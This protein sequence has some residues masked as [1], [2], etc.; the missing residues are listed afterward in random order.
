MRFSPAGALS[1]LL[2]G[3]AVLAADRLHKFVQLDILDW[4][5]GEAVAVTSFFNYVLV[6]NTGVS[7]GL[8]SGVPPAAILAI[9]GVAMVFLA[10][11]WVA[12]GAPRVRLGLALCLGGALSNLID[13]WLWGAVADFFHFHWAGWSFYVFNIADM[14]ISLGAVVLIFDALWPK[15]DGATTLRPD[16]GL[17]RRD[18]V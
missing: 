3:L 11:W 5:G 8:L 15:R 18:E 1:S 14:A 6:W 13:R 9:T 4:T 7:Y 2:V 16:S 12:T 10:W 17:K